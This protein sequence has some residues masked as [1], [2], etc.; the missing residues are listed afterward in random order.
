MLFCLRVIPG[1]FFADQF[2]QC[3]YFGQPDFY[4][5]L[6]LFL[7]L[8]IDSSATFS[9]TSILPTGSFFAHPFFELT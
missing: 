4:L 3:F 5:V 2:S 7:R 9:L 6:L 1:L 8:L